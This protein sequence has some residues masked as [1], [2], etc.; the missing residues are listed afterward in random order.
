M[1]PGSGKTLVLALLIAWGF[2][3]RHRNPQNDRFPQAVLVCAPNLTVRKRLSVLLPEDPDNYYDAF[4]LVP[5]RYRSA[6]TRGRVLVT[7]WHAFALKSEHSE[8]GSSHRVVDKGKE[9][10]EA[11][12]RARLGD[13]VTRLPI[14]VLNDE[15]H[16][17]WRP[18][19]TEAA[20]ALKDAKKGLSAE[21]RDALKEDAE[22]ARVW[23]TGLDM[24]N[25]C[26]IPGGDGR[27]NRLPGILACVDMSATPFYLGNSGHPEGSPFPWLVSDFGLVDAIESG[28]TKIPRLPVMDDLGNKDEA[29]RPDPKYFRLWEN[30]NALCPA[31]D[32]VKGRA[33]PEAVYR[34]SEDALLTLASQWKVQFDKASGDAGGR[35][36]VPPVMIIVCP[37]TEV[38]QVFYQRISGEHEEQVPDPD[39]PKKVRTLKT[40]ST[41]AVFPDLL[42]N[43]ET[44]QHTIRIDSKLLA[45]IDQEGGESKDQA[46]LRLREL[47]DTVGKRGGRGEHVRCV[48]SVS[49]L[50][51]GWD[52]NNVTHILGLRAFGSQLLCEQ[53]VGRGLRRMNYTVDPDTGFLPAEYADV[54][55]IPFSLIPFKGRPKDAT[56]K[57]DPV[58]WQIFSVDERRAYEIRVPNV[59][60]YVYSLREQGITCDVDTLEPLV[61]DQ[62][63]GDTWLRPTRGYLEDP[64]AP[65]DAGDWIIHNRDE[66]YRSV[67]PQQ[68]LFQL[69]KRILDQLLEGAE[70]DRST[71][72]ILRLR[73]RHQLFPEVLGI[74]QRYVRSRVQFAHGLDARELA[75]EVHANR[76]VERVRDGILP[77][78]AKEGRLLPV[79]NSFERDTSTEI[80]PYSTIKRVVDLTKSHL[81]RAVL[82]SGPEGLAID[83]L[84]ESDAVE[85]YAPNDR[86]IGFRV[87]YEYEG[88]PHY[89]EPDFIVRLRGEQMLLLEIKG[90]K[91]RI[92]SP[93]LVPAKSAAARKWCEAVSNLGRYGIWSYRLNEEPAALR[94]LL[95]ELAGAEPL[96]WVRVQEPQLRRWENA[97]PLLS[98]RAL[99]SRYERGEQLDLDLLHDEWICW[100]DHPAFEKGMFVARVRDD[101][102]DPVIPPGAY[103]LFKPADEA[104][105][106]GDVVLVSNRGLFDS[107]TGGNWTVRRF[108]G[109]T[110]S[111]DGEWKHLAVRL[112]PENSVAP[113]LVLQ[114][115]DLVQLGVLGIM[116]EHLSMPE[117]TGGFD[118]MQQST[119]A[120]AA[121]ARRN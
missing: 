82:D 44:V 101:S 73:A 18:R 95:A 112:N 36:F 120:M 20:E 33:K 37:D 49:M 28:I 100:P 9:T 51:E 29:G 105:T 5:A 4:E 75:L 109:V 46:A 54:Y 117:R 53:V 6:L 32:K 2:C 57:P 76:L 47:I 41:G 30:V 88:Q 42:G 39:N 11:F 71:K 12:T 92:H 89:Y 24:I 116:V 56:P 17:C 94:G 113:A 74:V 83:A 115:E 99:A 97:V 27:G 121:E 52:A 78:A 77:A 23:L 96:P 110:R 98:L 64:D 21:E 114:L 66:Y 60:G 58:V 70:G 40:Y 91:G 43:S 107:F 14:L 26:G 81:N 35:P 93:D 61:V 103:V 48:I 22:E 106:V 38:S 3:N 65:K 31:G 104:P 63:P 8:G 90:V 50:S 55:G 85:C 102:M 62:T 15:G 34:Y 67:R 108:A 16:H 59:E 72:A 118:Y 84:E 13:M 1:A 87:P 119:Q 86:H 68:V 25:N 45:K 80:S 19:A 10:P 111:A 7:N 79:L 69:S